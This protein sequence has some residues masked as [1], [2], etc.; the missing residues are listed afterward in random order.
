[1]AAGVALVGAAVGAVGAISAGNAAKKQARQNQQ[2]YN[3]TA[4]QNELIAIENMAIANKEADA[5]L[6]T[7][8]Y[9]IEAKR[10]EIARLLSYQR[11]QEAISG[12]KYEGTPILTAE[13]SRF[14]GE[15]DVSTIWAN[16][17][18]EANMTRER[19]RINAQ[20]GYNAA[21]NMR[22]QGDIVASAGRNAQQAGY[23][24]G[25]STLL[26][27]VG[28]AYMISQYPDVA[29]RRYRT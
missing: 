16:A 10:K 29:T 25:A 6:G 27:G 15:Q 11:V 14:E 5:I 22:I 26:S 19:G 23:Y 8:Q 18:T 2:L 20:Q 1:M 9:N 3:Q 12:F 17:L 28:N 24:S 21:S 7:G 13:A 4:Y